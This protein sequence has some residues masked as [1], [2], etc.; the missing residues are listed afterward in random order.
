MND[1]NIF[2]DRVASEVFERI[3]RSSNAIVFNIPDTH[4]LKNIKSSLLRA[5]SLTHVPCVCTGLKR[6]HPGMHSPILFKF[7]SS[8]DPSE[9]LTS[10]NS[11]RQKQIFK[12]IKTLPNKT[13]CQQKAGRDSYRPPASNSQT[14]H[15]S[16]GRKAK[17][18]SKRTSSFTSI[19]P[20]K[21]SSESPKVQNPE[22]SNPNVGGVHPLKNV[23][24]DSTRS[25]C[26]HDE[27]DNT[28]QTPVSATP[29]Y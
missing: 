7:N 26:A 5:N 1:I 25:S 10:S 16:N 29:S 24:L 19:P 4:A 9:F 3:R 17:S 28:V 12:D 14:H 23:D 13:P 27:W 22:D 21:T 8:V 2:L 6:S 15:N 18:D 11:F 20:P